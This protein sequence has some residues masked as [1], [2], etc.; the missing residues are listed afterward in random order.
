M[1][2]SGNILKEMYTELIYAFII[3]SILW[4]LVY[5]QSRSPLKISKKPHQNPLDSSPV[6]PTKSTS[7]HQKFKTQYLKHVSQQ[8]ITGCKT[9]PFTHLRTNQDKPC[10]VPV[11]KLSANRNASSAN[12]QNTD[13]TRGKWLKWPN[14]L[15]KN[16][17][18]KAK[19]EI[20]IPTERKRTSDEDFIKNILM[21]SKLYEQIENQKV[22]KLNLKKIC[23]NVRTKV[24]KYEFGK[25]TMLPLVIKEKVVLLVG[26]TGSGKT[27]LINSMINYV[28]GVEYEDEFR[29]K[30]VTQDDEETQNQAHSQTS[31][32]TAY[33][34]HH[35]KGFKVDYT[36]TI[37]DTPGFGDTR[38]INRDI[39]I[40]KQIRQF[41]NA[42][43]D[44]G[45]DRIDVVGFVAQ[46]SLPR[47]D[48]T[49]KYIFDNILSLFGKDIGEN[50]YLMLT[51]A[52][53]KV[54][55]ILTGIQ[56]AHLQFQEYFKFNNSVVFGDNSS[57]DEISKMFWK[58]GMDSFSIFFNR[59]SKIFTKSLSQS[60]LAIMERERIE[61][62]IEAL[63]TQVKYGI[64]KLEQLKTEAEIVV[65]YQ[66]DIARNRDFTYI[67]QEDVS[68]KQ[69]CKP[70][71]YVTNCS[72]CNFTCHS[73]CTYPNN[74]EKYKCRAMNGGG[75]EYAKCNVCPKRC[76][77]RNHK[78]MEYYFTTERVSVTKDSQDLKQRYQAANGRVKSA[79][80]IVKD[81]EN[82]YAA[83]QSNIVVIINNLSNS[84]NQLNKLALKPTS[85]STS[86]YVHILIESEKSSAKPGWQERVLHL[87]N[88][89]A[90]IDNP[91]KMFEWNAG[92]FEK[93]KEP[94][95]VGGF[96]GISI[97]AF[98]N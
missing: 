38:G 18:P 21:Q 32:I 58:M 95:E 71:T 57:E 27:T 66:E 30:L 15:S 41:F 51:F 60:K 17:D 52:D 79:Q 96:L 89:K 19:T 14:L 98:F 8:P 91:H 87:T 7:N 47:L 75:I 50:I 92:T 28:F 73:A 69:R 39:E 16:V 36:L 23:T 13:K 56:E 80:Q 10:P 81:V 70:N 45:I 62:Q 2:K 84:I 26:A 85:L 55:Q 88:V 61:I 29:F 93:V 12:T 43:G 34:I 64:S 97:A 90:K 74:E 86:G 33:T 94:D 54:P 6:K 63:Q 67:V 59:F 3:I 24:R 65:H 20:I 68:V 25:S 31:W 82:E 72:A 49:Q 22:Y 1:N 83:V 37:V 53:G 5:L 35:Q 9:S 78:N 4:I 42:K 44:Q 46:S 40:T 76:H 48:H 11:E 77:W